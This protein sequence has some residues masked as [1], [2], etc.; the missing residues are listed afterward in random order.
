MTQSG[1]KK[2]T[3]DV[4]LST[5][6]YDLTTSKLHWNIAISNPGNKYLVVGVNNFYLSNPMSEHEYYK[7]TLSL[8]LQDVINKYN[9]MDKQINGFI[10]VR[11]E[12]V[13]HG[14]V[15]AGIIAHTA[16]KEHL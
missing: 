9:L 12:K 7:I 14:L 3:F 16:L 4:P 5:P 10:Y 2:I 15:Q 1:R 13:I 6:I 11:V 8:I